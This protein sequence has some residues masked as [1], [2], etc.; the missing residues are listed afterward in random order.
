M[1]SFN[2]PIKNPLY[3]CASKGCCHADEQFIQFNTPFSPPIT[4]LDKEQ[5]KMSRD[6]VKLFADFA[7][8]E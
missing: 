2:L 5:Y 1:V 6:F 4:P 8:D 7:K 3:Y